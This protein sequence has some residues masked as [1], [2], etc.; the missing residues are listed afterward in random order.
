MDFNEMSKSWTR[1]EKIINFS[2]GRIFMQMAMYAQ[3]TVHG[4]LL[5]LLA[6]PIISRSKKSVLNFL[7]Q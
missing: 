6:F 3:H 7:G 5:V 1:K 4:Q 2:P